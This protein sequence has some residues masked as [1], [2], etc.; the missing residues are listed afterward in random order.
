MNW[1]HWKGEAAAWN[2]A[3][4]QLTDQT[5]YQAHGWGEHKRDSG[6]TPHRLMAAQGNETVAIAQVLVRSYALGVGMAWVPGG[7]GTSPRRR[8]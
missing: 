2:E 6:W 1:S 8:R 3:L 7:P 4:A 5:I